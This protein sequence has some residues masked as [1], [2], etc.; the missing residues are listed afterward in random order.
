MLVWDLFNEETWIIILESGE[1]FWWR[2]L[3]NVMLVSVI[4]KRGRKPCWWRNSCSNISVRV[5]CTLHNVKCNSKPIKKMNWL[6]LKTFNWHKIELV[7][8]SCG[9]WGIK[10][11]RMHFSDSFNSYILPVFVFLRNV[12]YVQYICLLL[13]R[14]I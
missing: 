13:R 11:F 5:L 6:Y 2:S 10:P 4:F 12:S 7:A 14:Q 8:V 9:R 3:F 1:D